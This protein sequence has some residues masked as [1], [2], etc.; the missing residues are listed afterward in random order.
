MIKSLE[1]EWDF[2]PFEMEWIEFK[3]AGKF[4]FSGFLTHLESL[5]PLFVAFGG[6]VHS[7]YLIL[8]Y[9]LNA[10]CTP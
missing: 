2:K 4:T 10:W 1:R 9:I 5:T 7:I 6:F 3:N 8:P